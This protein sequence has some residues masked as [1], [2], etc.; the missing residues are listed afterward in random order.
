MLAQQAQCRLLHLAIQAIGARR[1]PDQIRHFLAL[2]ER[3]GLV[4]AFPSQPAQAN[5]MLAVRVLKGLLNR[6]RLL[7]PRATFV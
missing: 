7:V 4:P 5:V 1:L 6:A 3:M 2:E